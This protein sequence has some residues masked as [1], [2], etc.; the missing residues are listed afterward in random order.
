[1]RKPTVNQDYQG[2]ASNSQLKRVV[3]SL[4]TTCLAKNYMQVGIS[5]HL[6]LGQILLLAGHMVGMAL[7]WK[8]E[9]DLHITEHT[10]SE[11]VEI[12]HSLIYLILN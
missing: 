4:T 10:V 1:M 2:L 6:N 5:Q 9:L 11:F 3:L 8:S 12:S 7:K